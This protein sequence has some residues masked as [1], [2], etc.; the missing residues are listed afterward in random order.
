MSARERLVAYHI[1]RLSDKRA[2]VRLAAIEELEL[3][4]ATE[5][6]ELLKQIYHSDPDLDVKRRAQ[7]AGRTLYDRLR[8]QGG[9]PSVE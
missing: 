9:S 2:E 8:Q 6:Y 5:A 7:A 1:A 4:G 3:L